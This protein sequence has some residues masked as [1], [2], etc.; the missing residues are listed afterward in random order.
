MSN[1]VALN[2]IDHAKLRVETRYDEESV[3]NINQALVF[4][5]EFAMLQREYPIFFRQDENK[6]F[7]AVVLLGLDKDENLFIDGNQWSARYIPAMQERGPFILENKGDDPVVRLN[8]DDARV[9]SSR[10]EN[11]FLTHG[12]YTA[13]FESILKT[14]QRLHIGANI[15]DD[16]FSHLQSFD[17]IDSV[18]VQVNLSEDRRYTIPDLFTVSKQK[19]MELSGQQLFDLN[20]LGLLEHCFAILSSASNV[21]RL[22]DMKALK[23]SMTI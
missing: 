6:A 5:T 17:L 9:S 20:Q 8:L 21:S 2:N 1:F 7:H 23:E 13:Y 18:N 11:I 22:A 4:P 3:N 19:M 15:V 16:F 14:L 10:G 12:G